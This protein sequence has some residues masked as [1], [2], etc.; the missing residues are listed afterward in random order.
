MATRNKTAKIVFWISTTLLAL[1]ILPGAFFMNSEMA[2]QGTAH[3]QVPKWLALEVGI[4]QPIGALF[5]ILPLWV[6][7]SKNGLM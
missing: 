1:F 2:Q 3:L 4:G 6:N 7:G 5:L